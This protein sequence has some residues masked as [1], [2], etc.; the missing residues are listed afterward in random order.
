VKIPTKKPKG[1]KLSDEQK[2]Q[3]AQFPLFVSWLNI[4]L[5]TQKDV[6]TVKD[7]FRCHKFG[8]EDLVLELAC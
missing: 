3:I 6:E 7:C 5:V 2:M 8:F 4:Q 1:K